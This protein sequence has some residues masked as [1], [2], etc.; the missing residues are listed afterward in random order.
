[1][2]AGAHTRRVPDRTINLSAAPEAGRAQA[3]R[4]AAA[5]LAVGDLV[6][7]PTET[8]YG[9]FASA[10]SPLATERLVALADD[11]PGPWAWHAPSSADVT[12]AVQLRHPAHR[13]LL[14]RLAPGP[15]TFLIELPA[16]DLAALRER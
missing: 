7:L 2:S 9:L 6:V 13:R 3:V 15:V 5:A 4:D 10:K 1:M 12:A 8:V 14:A 16:P 11:R